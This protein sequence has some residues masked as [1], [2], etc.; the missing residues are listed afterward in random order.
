MND[1]HLVAP[2]N[3]AYRANPMA[4]MTHKEYRAALDK[5]GLSQLAAGELFCVGPRTSRRW[6]LKEARIPAA[7]AILLRLLLKKKITL[8]DVREVA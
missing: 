4:T 8:E 7:V 1:R 5:L 6:A 3:L 2:D